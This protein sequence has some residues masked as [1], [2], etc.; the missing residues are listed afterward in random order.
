MDKSFATV[1]GLAVLAA[2]AALAGAS[3]ASAETAAASPYAV[4]AGAVRKSEALL[5]TGSKLS[6]LMAQQQ[7]VPLPAAAPTLRSVP[8]VLR[9]PYSDRPIALA[10]RPVASGRP[11]VFGSVALNITSTPLDRRWQAVANRP[12]GSEATRWAASL[13]NRSEAERIEQVN[14][15]VNARIAFVDDERQFG[16]PD[17]WQTAAESLRRGRGDCEDY[18]LAKRELLRAAGFAERDLY[19][20]ILKDLVRRSDHAVLAVASGGRLLVLDNGTDRITDSADIR[21]YRPIFSYSAGRSWTHGYRRD[22]EPPMLLAAATPTGSEAL[23]VPAAAPALPEMRA[24]ELR[25]TVTA[26]DLG[27]A[28]Q[29]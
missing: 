9:S 7:G 20:V 17:V 21:D 22:A 2:T 19:L 5:G 13:R 16:R 12:A 24:E 8:A 4:S 6:Q 28:A 15:F 11:D 1:L 18:A 10:R 23:P 14:R 3:P 27:L 26:A 25:F 29:G